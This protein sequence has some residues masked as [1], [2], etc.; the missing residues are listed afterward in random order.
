[1]LINKKI[2]Q[3]SFHLSHYFEN[4][5]YY[6][7]NIHNILR[8]KF[9][10]TTGTVHFNL[11]I[12]VTYDWQKLFYQKVPINRKFECKLMSHLLNLLIYITF[13]SGNS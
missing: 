10:N 8:L 7:Y 6:I 3:S 9:M 5:Q 12:D 4:L 13:S 1:M 11:K 2:V